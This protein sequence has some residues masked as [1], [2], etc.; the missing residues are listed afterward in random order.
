M[1]QVRI[2]ERLVILFLASQPINCLVAN[3]LQLC[4]VLTEVMDRTSDQALPRR[5]GRNKEDFSKLTN[6]HTGADHHWDS[7]VRLP[8]N[9]FF[10]AVG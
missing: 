2:L 7:G 8:H 1:I 5:N 10:S 6:G 4:Y 3:K 9:P